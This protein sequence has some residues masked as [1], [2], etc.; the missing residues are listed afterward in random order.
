MVTGIDLVK[1]QIRIAAGEPLPFTP[2]RDRHPRPLLRVPDQLRGPR[3]RLPP[4]AR[5]ITAPARPRRPG[6]ALGLA[7]PGRLLRPAQLRLAGRQA[8]RPRPDPRRGPRHDAPGPRRAGHRGHPDHD[9]APPP[10][11]PQPRLHRGPRRHH[12]GRARPHARQGRAVARRRVD[13]SAD[14][15]ARVDPGTPP[16][17]AMRR[18]ASSRTRGPRG[19]LT[20][21]APARRVPVAELGIVP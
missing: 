5:P 9:P 18:S 21:S 1:Q 14:A 6:R 17:D 15:S 10:D 4:L 8:D 2:G 3:P 7:R 19:R 20:R 16:A 13:P 11:L 12:L